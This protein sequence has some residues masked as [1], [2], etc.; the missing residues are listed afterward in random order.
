[1]LSG[2]HQKLILMNDHDKILNVFLNGNKLE[3][4]TSEKL[5]GVTIDESKSWKQQIKVLKELSHIK[6]RYYAE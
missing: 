2:T 3:Q 1:M 5:L 4:V 6:Y